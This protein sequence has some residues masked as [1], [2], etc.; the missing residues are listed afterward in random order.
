MGCCNEW[1]SVKCWGFCLGFISCI[2]YCFN[3]GGIGGVVYVGGY[4][5]LVDVITNEEELE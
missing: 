3:V 2:A 5:F 1:T 4:F